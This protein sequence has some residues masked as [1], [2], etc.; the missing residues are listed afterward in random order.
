[1]CYGSL[2]LLHWIHWLFLLWPNSHS[3]WVNLNQTFLSILVMSFLF[4]VS[5][6]VC[7]WDVI[8]LKAWVGVTLVYPHIGGVMGWVHKDLCA[9]MINVRV[10]TSNFLRTQHSLRN[11]YRS[12]TSTTAELI[13]T[14]ARHWNLTLRSHSDWFADQPFWIIPYHPATKSYGSACALHG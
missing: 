10:F 1:M 4:I 6:C 13:S 7:V 3:R 11:R 8:L 12:D 5:V 14:Q 9:K 2:R